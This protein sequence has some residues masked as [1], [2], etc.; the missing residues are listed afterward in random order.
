MTAAHA[1]ADQTGTPTP[2]PAPQPTPAPQ[3][4][5]PPPP[6]APFPQ[7]AE[8]GKSLADRGI[9]LQLGYTYDLDALVSGGLKTGAFGTGE[10]YF[11]TVLDLQKIMGLQ[12]ASIHITFDERSGYNVNANVGTQGP[13]QSNSGPTRA[14]RL[15][16]F[17]WEQ[18]IDND[19]LD[20]QVGR[21]NPTTNFATSD[22]AC[23]FA[24]SII[25][26][27]PGSWYFSN[28]NQA[29][30][31]ST[32]GGFVNFLVNPN[33]YVRA[34]AYQDDPRQAGTDEQGFSW[35]FG[36]SAGVF[37][38]AEVGYQTTFDNSR[39][40]AKYDVGGYWDDADFTAPGGIPRHGR[41]AI[42][43][44]AEQT[45]WRPDPHTKESIT[46]FGGGIFYNGNA[47]YW[48]QVYAGVYD[49]AP[50]DFR[51]SDTIG[52][53]GSYYAN[54]S[55]RRPNS[56]SQWI[57]ELNY[58]YSIATGITFKPFVQYVI[59]PNNLDAPIG[60]REPSNAWLIGFQVTIDAASFLGF[61]KFVAY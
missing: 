59:S 54:N 53:I 3:P 31:V 12:G 57:F 23:E 28:S 58:G 22:I 51:P 29:Y 6:A 24:S 15:S 56:K 11:G 32:W 45:V 13:L 37:V 19:R 34:G 40:P 39:Y 27:Q 61:P 36:G 21:T 5:A 44:Q 42:Y 33:V 10:L 2:I 20:I 52:L 41:S 25:C 7:V 30:P 47:P 35:R 1:Q 4:Q 17:Y 14:I 55:A 16:Q 60:S 8:F 48:T 9:F 50:F 46:L 49:R 26:A 38:P 18:A 43:A